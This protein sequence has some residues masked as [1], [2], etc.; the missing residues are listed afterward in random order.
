[1]NEILCEILSMCYRISNNSKADVFFNYSPH[2]D[3][4]TVNYYRDGWKEHHLEEHDEICKY[5][6]MTEG[7]D[8][9]NLL[10]C[11]AELMKLAEELGVV[12]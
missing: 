8:E 4:F 7:I 6:A 5:I 9:E 3:C 10:S 1:M 12:L 2:C 11:K